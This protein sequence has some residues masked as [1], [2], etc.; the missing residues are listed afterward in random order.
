[1]EVSRINS[2]AP[3]S[4]TLATADA[5]M[6]TMV[7]AKFDAWARRGVQVVWTHEAVQQ[8]DGWLVRYG[9]GWIESVSRLLTSHAPPFPLERVLADLRRRLAARV[10]HWKAE[11]RRYRIQQEAHAAAIA[12]VQRPPSAQLVERRRLAVRKYR[13]DHDLDAVGFAQTVRIDE[14]V[15]SAIIRGDW[16]RFK[17]GAQEKLLAVIGMT[18]EDW[19][20]E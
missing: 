17:R 20:R 7:I 16:K 14:T 18:R 4:L 10:H 5:W 9:N 13:D 1:M 6:P 3:S 8:Y 12:E 15:V 19:Y 11:A 2:E